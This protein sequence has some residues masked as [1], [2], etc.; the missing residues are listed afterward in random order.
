M[1]EEG[2][3][4]GVLGA[5]SV[6]SVHLGSADFTA[7]EEADLQGVLVTSPLPAVPAL[8]SQRFRKIFRESLYRLDCTV[9]EAAGVQGVLVTSGLH[10]A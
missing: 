7:L 3:L 10:S 9:L 1:L 2:D 8:I 5:C 6:S 4:Q